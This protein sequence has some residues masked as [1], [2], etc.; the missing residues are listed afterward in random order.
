MDLPQSR[1]SGFRKDISGCL[2]L[3]PRHYF[4]LGP[5][6]GLNLDGRL[7]FFTIPHGKALI[8]GTV[9]G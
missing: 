3:K 1:L 5:S 2:L 9:S 4:Q 6:A 8:K 7:L